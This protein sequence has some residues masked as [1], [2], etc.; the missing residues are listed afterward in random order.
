MSEGYRDEFG[1]TGP[2]PN[3]FPTRRNPGPDFPTGPS[4]GERVPDFQLPNQHGELVDFRAALDGHKAV[5]AFQ[6]SAVW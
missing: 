2:V 1:F 4:A 5:L 3:E 6:R